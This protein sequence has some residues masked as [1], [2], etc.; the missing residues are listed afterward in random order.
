M[1]A[2]TDFLLLMPSLSDGTRLFLGLML[3]VGGG[4]WLL[5]AAYGE[6]VKFGRLMCFVP[7]LAILFCS[8]HPKRGIPPLIIQFIG[9]WLFFPSIL[10][11]LHFQ[12]GPTN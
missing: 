7:G 9:A 5:F 6:D 11:L 2:I 8:E 1:D 10:N 4:V 12:S 3:M